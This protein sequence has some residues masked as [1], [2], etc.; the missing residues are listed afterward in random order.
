MNLDFLDKSGTKQFS[1]VLKYL[2]N[3]NHIMHPSQKSLIENEINRKSIIIN[4]FKNLTK[5]DKE[6][7]II[8]IKDEEILIDEIIKAFVDFQSL[9]ERENIADFLCEMMKNIHD[10]KSQLEIFNLIYLNHSSLA[11][12]IIYETKSESSKKELCQL[13]IS[14]NL[15][16]GY[17]YSLLNN[18]EMNIPSKLD[19]KKL[20]DEINF[21]QSF[22]EDLVLKRISMDYKYLESL[23]EEINNRIKNQEIQT[24]ITL[25]RNIELLKSNKFNVDKKNIELIKWAIDST[26]DDKYKDLEPYPTQWLTFLSLNLLQM[27]SSKQEISIMIL[28]SILNRKDLI[29]GERFEMG[30]QISLSVK[31]HKKIRDDLLG[32]LG[33]L[34]TMGG[35]YNIMDI[36]EEEGF[37]VIKEDGFKAY[38]SKAITDVEEFKWLTSLEKL[39]KY[40]HPST[41]LNLKALI[42]AL[43]GKAP[44]KNYELLK[45]LKSN[46]K[47]LYLQIME[48]IEEIIANNLEDSKKYIKLII[49]LNYQPKNREVYN[50]VKEYEH[51]NLGA[52][53]SFIDICDPNL[54]EKYYIEQ[55]KEAISKNQN[56][57]VDLLKEIEETQI[58]NKCSYLV[59]ESLIE[60]DFD[61]LINIWDNL[62][63]DIDSKIEF[64][65]KILKM[66]NNK[67]IHLTK[68]N[69]AFVNKIGVEPATLYNSIDDEVNKLHLLDIWHQS[70]EF[71]KIVN[72]VREEL[73]K[74]AKSL[75]DLKSIHELLEDYNISD[76]N[77]DLL[78]QIKAYSMISIELLELGIGSEDSIDRLD[79]LSNQLIF[80]RLV[81]RFLMD[82]LLQ[83]EIDKRIVDYLFR[84]FMDNVQSIELL[85]YYWDNIMEDMKGSHDSPNNWKLEIF[86]NH[87]T[88][89]KNDIEWFL[90]II[91]N[92]NIEY[93][94]CINIIETLLIL[95]NKQNRVILQNQQEIDQVERKILT[96]VGKTIGKSLGNMEKAIVNRT[97][98]IENDVLI[99]NVKRFRRELKDIGIGTVEDIENY[100]KQVKFNNNLHENKQLTDLDEGIV[101]SLGIKINGENISLSTLLNID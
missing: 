53:K 22:S 83:R 12:K 6:M 101:D 36:V 67:E 29:S 69:I 18:I 37:N 33:E 99:E 45:L 63:L 98:N 41:D 16:R 81:D 8:N 79:K 30:E 15:E 49:V 93:D 74:N 68:K 78:I 54:L 60:K 58:K 84:T 72:I 62:T 87:L 40:K 27:D 77:V 31:K 24:F 92:T 55:I 9:D 1:N 57:I 65:E 80:Y 94:I 42:F 7:L 59:L 39:E 90:N 5:K 11:L 56:N 75:E 25:A 23:I 52:I 21:V 97:K 44:K 10:K 13:C 96:G 64:R 46:N 71:G 38:I 47:D 34:E 43:M 76:S 35:F 28:N 17:I 73:I 89:S 32:I 20:V 85:E 14:S 100:G 3:P 86:F 70:N 61:E 2:A 4:S 88:K 95:V 91:D 51:K 66:I 48:N 50:I 26:G 82:K 19:S